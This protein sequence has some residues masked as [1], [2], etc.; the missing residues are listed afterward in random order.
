MTQSLTQKK[1]VVK[2]CIVM[3]IEVVL[4]M[5]TILD[6]L[7]CSKQ[8]DTYWWLHQVQSCHVQE[9][10]SVCSS[11]SPRYVNTLHFCGNGSPCRREVGLTSCLQNFVFGN[12]DAF[13]NHSSTWM[14]ATEW[15]EVLKESTQS[16]YFIV[17]TCMSGQHI[18]Q[19]ILG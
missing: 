10:L 4:I 6:M 15:H 5:A 8:Q 2:V 19:E 16:R 13:C 1:T 9:F 17:S 12:S 7:T 3:I 11:V 14:P 18:K